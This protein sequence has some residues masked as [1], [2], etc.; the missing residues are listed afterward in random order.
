MY[1]DRKYPFNR[2]HLSEVEAMLKSAGE[3]VVFQL[4]IAE[5]E[6]TKKLMKDIDGISATLCD[7]HFEESPSDPNIENA[8]KFFLISL[9]VCIIRKFMRCVLTLFKSPLNQLF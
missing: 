6:E 7:H 8:A 9:S 1:L 4:D 3:Y 5:E 2:L